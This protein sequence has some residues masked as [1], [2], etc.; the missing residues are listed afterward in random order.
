M[1]DV[2]N[3]RYCYHRLVHVVDIVAVSYAER[4]RYGFLI[5]LMLAG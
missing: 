1:T 3:I 5:S 4:L 2:E